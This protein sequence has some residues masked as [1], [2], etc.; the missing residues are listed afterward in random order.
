[1]EVYFSDDLYAIG[2]IDKLYT[3]DEAPFLVDLQGKTYRGEK[4][5]RVLIG[6]S[7]W[8]R[9]YCWKTLPMWTLL[10]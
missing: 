1:M 7:E 3:A 4:V 6:C 5:W 10:F 9:W 8:R 2:D